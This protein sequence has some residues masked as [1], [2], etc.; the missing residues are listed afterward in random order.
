MG[1]GGIRKIH[2]IMHWVDLDAGKL[3]HPNRVGLHEAPE[4]VN[5]GDGRRTLMC[6][7]RPVHQMPSTRVLAATLD[8]FFDSPMSSP[9]P[10]SANIHT[11]PLQHALDLYGHFT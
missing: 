2:R 10:N 6:T 11:A 7:G 1:G 8:L 5:D 4:L 3:D 9:L